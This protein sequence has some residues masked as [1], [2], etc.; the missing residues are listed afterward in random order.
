VNVNLTAKQQKKATSEKY[1]VDYLAEA[2][3]NLVAAKNALV[4]PDLSRTRQRALEDDVTFHGAELL[5]LEKYGSNALRRR[6]C[7]IAV[8]AHEI[9]RFAP[10]YYHKP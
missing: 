9:D 6:A 5:M 3:A 7:R 2:E 1:Q 4:E 8:D 10:L